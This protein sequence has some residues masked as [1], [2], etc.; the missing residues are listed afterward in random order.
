MVK[1]ERQLMEKLV[2]K[3]TQACKEQSDTL[4][5]GFESINANISVMISEITKLF[6][7]SQRSPDTENNSSKSEDFLTEYLDYDDQ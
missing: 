3:I 2:D 1:E 4:K 6:K 5:K 7:A